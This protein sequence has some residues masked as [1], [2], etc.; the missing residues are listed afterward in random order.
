MKWSRKPR[1]KQGDR[2]T[3]LVFAW[4]PFRIAD[5][6]VWLERYTV[7]EEFNE[8]GWDD[9]RYIAKWVPIKLEIKK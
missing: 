7:H 8:Y 3:R 9:D 4:F 1:P 6:V 2:R 5:T